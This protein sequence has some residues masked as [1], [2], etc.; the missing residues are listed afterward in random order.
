MLWCWSGVGVECEDILFLVE[1]IKVK[2][3]ME[4]VVEVIVK[5]FL[6]IL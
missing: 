5:V 2:T 3:V 6:G 4:V 1:V